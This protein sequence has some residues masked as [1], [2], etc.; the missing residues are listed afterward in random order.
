MQLS[1]PAHN[2]ALAEAPANEDEFRAHEEASLLSRIAQGDSAGFDELHRRY[3]SMILSCAYGV[4]GNREAAEDVVQDVLLQIWK[5]APTYHAS[6]GKASTWL[7]TLARN[8]SI[9]RLRSI[10]RRAKLQ[11]T[12]EQQEKS[13]LQFDDRDSLQEALRNE[14]GAVLREALDKLNSE[15]RESIQLAFFEQLPYPAVAQRL[16]V[17]LATIKARIRRGLMKL[18]ELVQGTLQPV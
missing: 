12:V 11:E 18:R 3:N 9:D 8:K 16:G 17:R 7:I 15:Q 13:A 2:T 1:T 6:R 10:Q 4:L 5:K 14:R